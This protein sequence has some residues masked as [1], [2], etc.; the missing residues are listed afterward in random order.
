MKYIYG[1]KI[2]YSCVVRLFKPYTKLT[3]HCNHRSGHLK[4]EHTESLLLLR[5][6][7]GNWYRGLAAGMRSLLLVAH[8]KLGQFS[9][10]TVYVVPV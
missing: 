2:H 1:L 4:M 10:L 7:L 8:G 3:L 9:L 5:C 6:H